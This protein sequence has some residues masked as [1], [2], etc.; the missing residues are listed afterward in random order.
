M[1]LVQRFDCLSCLRGLRTS[2]YPLLP[3]LPFLLGFLR[4]MSFCSIVL[5]CKFLASTCQ[6]SIVL[7]I[8]RASCLR[9][10]F[11]YL[12]FGCRSSSLP[13]WC[14]FV[15]SLSFLSSI[16]RPSTPVIFCSS[17]ISIPGSATLYIAAYSL[18]PQVLPYN[19][20]FSPSSLCIIRIR[21]LYRT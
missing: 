11:S 21:Y 17:Y 7:Y 6:L 2:S 1:N 12:A 18:L 5:V 4:R 9:M 10:D 14:R 20:F 16:H 19:S 15:L 13:S 8:P 3:D